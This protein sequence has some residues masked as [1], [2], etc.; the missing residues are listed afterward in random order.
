MPKH[1][2]VQGVDGPS[3]F[4]IGDIITFKLT[5][6]DTNNGYFIVEVVSEPGGG[7]SFLHTHPP[8]ETFY[9]LEGVFEVYGQDENGQKYA[10]RAEVGDVVHVPGNV[11][12]G[13]KNVGDGP[14]RM[15][16][17]YHPADI[18]HNF[19]REVGV[20]MTDRH[21]LPSPESL[22][23]PA[24]LMPILEKYMSILETPG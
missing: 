19:F 16:L 11:P 23:D 17:T 15:I 21:T 9:V 24:T 1:V 10:I 6:A 13:F 7:P 4:V 3:Y 8:E 18:M 5:G 22:P 2:T 12:H 14:G 20:P